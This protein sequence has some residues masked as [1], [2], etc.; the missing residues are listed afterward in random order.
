[1]NARLSLLFAVSIFVIAEIAI[2]DEF[3]PAISRTADECFSAILERVYTPNDEQ[4]LT[5]LNMT[6]RGAGHLVQE[7]S[8]QASGILITEFVE[9]VDLVAELDA[10]HR[11]RAKE[12][13]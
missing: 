11:G 12:E 9:G 3:A 13:I 2:A 8:S 7:D 6:T 10:P 1:M 5:A 4:V